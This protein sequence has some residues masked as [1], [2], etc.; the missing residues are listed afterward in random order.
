MD[1]FS[2]MTGTADNVKNTNA[3]LQTTVGSGLESAMTSG[4]KIGDKMKSIANNSEEGRR[5]TD[6]T[7]K[8]FATESGGG[9]QELPLVSKIVQFVSS[10]AKVGGGGF[11]AGGAINVGSLQLN[12]TRK[13]TALQQS[14]LDA[15]VAIREN[16][17]GNTEG[18]PI[19]SAVVLG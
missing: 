7:L 1:L 13:Q 6:D 16:L 4:A 19:E 9:K 5:A 18:S 10:M 8:S 12:E 17:R 11:V 2:K 15:L 3:E 14:Q